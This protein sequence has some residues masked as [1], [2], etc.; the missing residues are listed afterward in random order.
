MINILLLIACICVDLAIL[1]YFFYWNR[2]IA[3]I[4][5]LGIR[6]VY[7][8]QGASSL[9]LE[10]GSIQF[11]L[12]T[13]RILLKD[14]RYHTSNQTI[15]IVKAQI[16]WRYW[17]RGPMTE[18]DIGGLVGEE[19][20]SAA[21]HPPCR[22]KISVNGL[23]W[24]LYNRTAAYDDILA[25]MRSNGTASGEPTK[26]RGVLRKSATNLSVA[27]PSFL[28]NS[29]RSHAPKFISRFSAWFKQQL[30]TLDPKDLLP[31]A[32]EVT[33][34]AII[35]GNS[36]TPSLLVVEFQRAVGTFGITQS[37]SQFDHYK[38]MLSLSFIHVVVRLKENTNY[39]ETMTATG[40]AVNN[41]LD[42]SMQQGAHHVTYNAFSKLWSRLKLYRKV[43]TY[44]NRQR[45]GSPSKAKPKA[46][47]ED[48]PIGVEFCSLEYAVERKILETPTLEL[49][50]YVDV[51]GEV[52]SPLQINGGKVPSAIIDIGNGDAGPEWGLDLVVVGGTIRYGPWAD[53][54][55]AELQRVFFPPTY[56]SAH[57]TAQLEPGDQRLWT[58]FKLFIE[59]REDVVLHVPFREASKN[60][61]WDGLTDY[62]NRP[63][64][65]EPS[66]LHITAGDR[67]SI[68]YL[69]PMVA[70]AD[71]YESILE[72]H[73]D[74]MTLTSSLNDIRLI[75][76]ESCRLH[77]ELPSPLRW[78]A[79]REWLIS[80]SLRSP[81]LFILRDHINMFTDLGKDWASGP[82]TQHHRFVPVV[83]HVDLELY[84]YELNL[85]ANDQN[86]VDKPLT[87]DENAILTLSGSRLQNRTTL[88]SNMFRPE[89]TQV[90]FFVEIPDVSLR[91]SLP[92]WNIHAP[93]APQDGSSLARVGSLTIRGSYLYYAEVHEEN[94]EQLKMNLDAHNVVFKALGWSIRYFMIVREN[95][96]GSFTHFS[97]LYEYLE[98]RDRGLPPGDPVNQKYREGKANMLHVDLR[99]Q[100]QNGTTLLPAG[101]PGHELSRHAPDAPESFSKLGP[102]IAMNFPELQ[103]QLRVHDH[104]MEMSLNVDS[105]SSRIE[106]DLPESV[107]YYDSHDG[108]NTLVVDGIDITANRLFGPPPSNLTYVC[109]WE[110]HVGR[111]KSCITASEGSI[112]AGAGKTFGINYSDVLNAPASDYMPPSYPDLTFLKVTLDRCDIVWKTGNT[113]LHLAL[114]SGLKFDHNDLGGQAYRKLS[115]VALPHL[116]IKTFLK[117]PTD[118][119]WLEASS[120]DCDLYLDVYACPTDW[121]SAAERQAAFVEE[122]DQASGRA[123]KMFDVMRKPS[124]EPI[125]RTSH[126]SGLYLPP[127]RL[128]DRSR[129]C[130]RARRPQRH[131]RVD[132]DSSDSEGQSSDSDRGVT[133]SKKDLSSPSQRVQ[134]PEVVDASDNMSSGD[135]SDDEDL[136][137]RS[138][139]DWLERDLTNTKPGT[140]RLEHHRL[141]ARHYIADGFEPGL[142]DVFGP[143]RCIRNSILPPFSYLPPSHDSRTLRLPEN[144][145][146]N[147]STTLYRVV[148]RRTL[149]VNT[150]PLILSVFSALEEDVADSVLTPELV[151]DNAI[152]SFIARFVDENKSEA[153]WCTILDIQLQALVLR[154]VL[155][156]DVSNMK[157]DDV[158]AEETLSNTFAILE[159]SFRRVSL[160]GVISPNKSE[161]MAGVDLTKTHVSSLLCVE[162]T[163]P[164]SSP[165]LSISLG[166]ISLTNSEFSI[167]VGCSTIFLQLTHAAPELLVLA[168][169]S[170]SD[171]VSQMKGADKRRKERV[172]S[173]IHAAVYTIIRHSEDD[174]FIER[175]SAIQPSFLVQVGLPHWLRT[176]TIFRLLYHLRDC[177]WHL[178]EKGSTLQDADGF[179]V[180]G[181]SGQQIRD[182]L[183][184]RLKSLDSDAFRQADLEVLGSLFDY[185][186]EPISPAVQ[187]PSYFTKY[188]TFKIKELRVVV[189]DHS[190][191]VPS[192]LLLDDIASCIRIR[193]LDFIDISQGSQTSLRRRESKA[194]RVSIAFTLGVMRLTIYPHLLNVIQESLRVQRSY[195]RT[196]PKPPKIKVTRFQ[197]DQTRFDTVHFDITCMFG[198]LLVQAIAESL[199]FE[200]GTTRFHVSSALLMQRGHVQAMNHAV[201]LGSL[202]L[203]ARSPTRSSKRSEHDELA[204]LVTSDVRLSSVLHEFL[205]DGDR[206]L[207][208]G[209]GEFRF[210][211]PRSA[212]RLYH[213]I[214]EWREDFLPGIESTMQALLAEFERSSDKPKSPV[215]A[216]N[217]QYNV[218]VHLK[219]AGIYLRVMHN[220]W[221]SWEL[222]DAVSHLESLSGPP[223]DIGL[224]FGLHF[225]SQIFSIASF[226][227]ETR[228]ETVLKLKLP[229]LSFSGHYEKDRVHAI[230]L[231]QFLE[232]KIKPSHWDTL[233]GVQQK[234][235]QDFNDLVALVQKS[236][237]NR[238]SRDSPKLHKRSR[239]YAIFVKMEGFRIGFEGVSA[240]LYLECPGIGGR[241]ESNSEKNWSIVVS[242]LFL[243]LAPRAVM[244]FPRHQRSAFVVIDF[245][246]T[247]SSRKSTTSKPSEEL[248]LTVTKVH[249]VMQPSSIGEIGD[250]IDQ[251]QA[252]ML[253]RREQRSLELAAFKSKAQ[254]ILK[255]FEVVPS[256]ETE[257][258]RAQSAVPI[259]LNQYVIEFFIHSVGV[260][261]P[262]TYDHDNSFGERAVKAFLFSIKNIS[263]ETHRGE[264]GQAK[265][266]G[267]SFQFVSSFKQSDPQSFSGDNHETH[268]KL[269]YPEMEAQVHSSGS[270]LSRQIH[271]RAI[272]SGFFLDLDSAIPGY[273]FSLFDVYREGKDRV[274]KLS[275]NIP[276]QS[277]VT[278][279]IAQAKPAE[280]PT[281][282]FFASFSFRSGKVCMYSSAAIASSRE[283]SQSFTGRWEDSQIMAVGAE[284]FNLPEVSVWAEY[285][286][287]P[288]QRPG[289]LNHD[290]EPSILVFKST[291]HSSQ[292]VL[293]PTLLP[294]LTELMELV[295]NR[296]RAVRMPPESLVLTDSVPNAEDDE[297]VSV[298]QVPSLVQ[299]S[300]SL[301]IDQ[302]RLE[303]SCHPDV[304]V[305]AGL[306]WE[307][308]GFVINAS[309]GARQ[310]TFTGS[311]GGL[312]I[313]LKHGFLSEDC[314]RLDARNLGFSVA[315]SKTNVEEG[316][317]VSSVSFALDTEFHGGV[318]FSRLQDMLC[319]KAVWLDRIPVFNGYQERSDDSDLA[320]SKSIT[321]PLELTPKQM[322]TTIL[323][324]RI[325]QI[326]LDIDLGQSIT[327]MN[328]RL[329]DAVLRT[330]LTESSNEVF[331][332]VSDVKVLGTG[333]MAGRA[334]V[335]DFI[336][337]TVRRTNYRSIPRE[338]HG[339]MLEL[340][341][342]SGP[343]VIVI[344]S[345]YQRLLHYRA[346]PLQIEILDDWSMT[347]HLA[348]EIDH[349][350]RLSVTVSSPE[351]FAAATVSA[352]PKL[353][354]YMNRFKANLEAQRAGASRESKT[355]RI[356]QSPKP[357][358][359][360]SAVAEAM[361]HSARTRLKEA[362]HTLSYIIQQDMNLRLDL[363]RLIVFPRNMRDSEVAQ[364]VGRDVRGR[365]S[366]LV[367][368]KSMAAKRD[369]H[370]SFTFMKISRVTQLGNA[371][372]QSGDQFFDGKQW[373]EAL[374][375]DSS[376]A[377][378]V[379]LPSIKMHMK[380][381][382]RQQ[383]GKRQL[384]Y[385]FDSQ[386]IRGQ[387]VQV[388][389]DIYITLNVSLYSWLTTLRKTLTRE[390]EQVKATAEWRVLPSAPPVRLD[391][392]SSLNPPKA[393]TLPPP[394]VSNM[395]PA[396]APVNIEQNE[397]VSGD[398]LLYLP[399]TRSIER[400]T[401]RQLGDATPDVMHPFFMKK[402]GFSLED[403][404]PQYVHEYATTPL[405]EILEVLL[406]LYSKQLLV[407]NE[408][409]A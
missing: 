354:T 368:S 104:G 140:S 21:R 250:F 106:Q 109:I 23:E 206:R 358:N 119:V 91:L 310:V 131:S 374:L 63:R 138:D 173:V 22:I 19:D 294:F 186:P 248:K 28:A 65:R 123:A 337:Q 207:V 181:S 110:I 150:T 224:V 88:P 277:S 406:K 334:D 360:L 34:G 284:V 10:I 260:A 270:A 314:V 220:T 405:E 114:T 147:D 321:D 69:M 105:I 152:A 243:S 384:K 84:Q 56:Q 171:L 276:R 86:I 45:K 319:F 362:D 287:V 75:T 347:T 120:I 79:E 209:V 348:Q 281:S 282:N 99:V 395:S 363:L 216:I 164:S 46:N 280:L 219:S 25:Q 142:W 351:V 170:F 213:F 350:L 36:S 375:K 330:K 71:G 263:F 203:R 67:S 159:S 308:G 265:M 307:S 392:T 97:T 126:K 343:L 182:A 409:H 162:R 31:L 339:R 130:S 234:F 112:I 376:P 249:A 371:M 408:V 29:F 349:P 64:T 151:L 298:P 35:C 103:V 7:W 87:T 345:E 344:D 323:L 199:I 155:P 353:M 80:V 387:G 11:S 195:Q 122:Q 312:S 191:N 369:I 366:R 194:Q 113:A 137:D 258:E 187:S 297:G 268:N 370:L 17:I 218:Q 51:A 352:I 252:E 292:N 115:S 400:L 381:E 134:R 15:K 228:A 255:T 285:R 124:E 305:L 117:E 324:I 328:L 367:E 26:E 208:A 9:W 73:L 289:R 315:F 68:R 1:I 116:S 48:T 102:S 14:V 380:S 329:N 121:S 39:H 402:A 373:L 398:I 169:L 27:P 235:G 172:A 107:S 279:S 18:D 12:L 135:E 393:S 217:N 246:I 76:S 359:P 261:F 167:G 33:K 118:N 202:F 377:D 275:A 161:I 55:R 82:P 272:V 404:L 93:H 223:D 342:T 192:E 156:I 50:Y 129:Y 300:F 188:G 247:G 146:G 382:E 3:W 101:L 372:T 13:G 391:P 83:Y 296:L 303:L 178:R 302:S 163:L 136:T 240:V 74:V 299:V 42:N 205:S 356:S 78:N 89:H 215:R 383:D 389:E 184:T 204:S 62:P 57:P 185:E 264:T 58:A 293:R 44:F 320:S 385:D 108:S 4:L 336:F 165:A 176:N 132:V 139:S 128:S 174:L 242:D 233:L 283:R 98:R 378:I 237:V 335:S 66:H 322:F 262:L 288:P 166:E 364:F 313:G 20:V 8:N 2:F 340:R 379:G 196:D 200:L 92:R 214:E 286:A 145:F 40:E 95:Y 179:E 24:I 388:D 338:E 5:G 227:P 52:P 41:Y 90:S 141:L 390:M 127:P 304:N 396:S 168:G 210:T 229:S 245:R 333:N 158:R 154:V 153:T 290:V 198:D 241:L 49:L 222:R 16:M 143:F 72:A 326:T 61:Q 230:A 365:L 316:F 225:A 341:M 331:L 278:N 357:D 399:G 100:V 257:G 273:V 251:L 361:I 183:E 238:P 311:V 274:A 325:R 397:P 259:W 177:L 70:G 332:S 232:F 236:R 201:F 301:R 309:P 295:E 291:V 239:P 271:I 77:C 386:F 211:V 401:M 160:S 318:R 111:V 47:V 346:E 197:Q 269:L 175:L 231:M 148:Q 306:T 37:R 6:L 189:Q 125:G 221:L 193:K 212:L 254:Q 267:L 317:L 54:Q 149:E 96:L 355:F 81:T 157:H 133:F 60:W 226:Y 403:S 59:F 394:N 256:H 266:K 407:P 244:A 85:Y 190:S 30:P 43:T 53:R 253:E 180:Q 32:I 327:T 94:I 38:Q 144:D